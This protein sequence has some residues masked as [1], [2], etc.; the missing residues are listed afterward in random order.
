MTSDDDGLVEYEATEIDMPIDKGARRIR[1]LF[2]EIAPRYDILNHMLSFNL[3]PWWRGQAV[4]S[5]QLKSGHKVLD[6]CCGTGALSRAVLSAEPDAEITGSDFS[7]Q[8]L[9]EARE[10]QGQ[11]NGKCKEPVWV[12]ADTL[13]LPFDDNFFDRAMVGFGLRNVEEPQAALRELR[14]VLKPQ[15]LLMVLEF[16][17]MKNRVLRSL[18]NLYQGQ[19]LPRLGDLLSGTN[20]KAYSY[21]DE[22]VKSWPEADA[23]AQIMSSTPFQNVHW[24]TLFPGNVAVHQATK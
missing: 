18:S 9:A 20:N 7:T 15:G 5:L 16:T 13:D 21:L 14:R 3:D 12:H 1:G 11:L 10:R 24:R 8:M 6:A 23:L 17:Q 19:V 2:D 4:S 22:S